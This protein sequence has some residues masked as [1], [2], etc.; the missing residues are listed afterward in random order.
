MLHK[1]K[2]NILEINVKIKVLCREGG[3]LKRQMN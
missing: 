3:E 1:I 2:K